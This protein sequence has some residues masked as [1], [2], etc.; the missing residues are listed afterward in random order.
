MVIECKKCK[1]ETT[2]Y[3]AK[4][5]NGWCRDCRRDANADKNNSQNGLA[6]KR[7]PTPYNVG[8]YGFK[9]GDDF[10]YI[11]SSDRLPLR[12]YRH[13]IKNFSFEDGLNKLEREVRYSWHILWHGDSLEDAVHM[14]KLSIQTHQ[15]KFNKI[16]YKSYEG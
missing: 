4:D 2:N 16:K 15:P 12:I 5:V 14:E 1:I 7:Y 6:R 11:G 8:V 9:D 13:Y 10:I 3:T